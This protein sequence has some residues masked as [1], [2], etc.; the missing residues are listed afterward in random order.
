MN[1]KVT[2]RRSTRWTVGSLLMILLAAGQAMGQDWPQ[3]GHDATK[4]MVSP[5]AKNILTD[6]QPGRRKG[7]SEHIDPATTRNIRWIAKLG[8]Q[9]YGN[10]T[11]SNGRVFIGT[12]NASPRDPK[13]KG[14]RSTVY[15]LDEDTGQLLWQFNLRKLGAG[16]VSDWE[17]LGICSSPTVDGKHVYVVT[18]LGEVVCLDV[19]GMANGNNG[20]V[21]NEGQYLAGPGK[22]AI[23]M[24]ATDADVIWRFDMRSELGVFPH[25]VTSSSALVFGNRV[26]ATTS[27]GVDWSHVNIP[28]PRAPTLIAMD[29][30]TGKLSG[31]ESSGISERLLHCNWSSPGAGEAN[32]RPLVFFGGGDGFCYAF[33]PVPVPDEDG[34]GI[35]KEAWR[36]DCN[37]AKYRTKEG[38]PIRYATHDGPS[39]L[40]ATPVFHK[41]R[42]YIAVG[43]DPEHGEGLGALSCIDAT[44]RGDIS[45]NGLIWRYTEI[46][47]TISTLSIADG[48]V[49][50]AD[51]AGIVHCLDAI[52]GEVFWKHD[53]LGHIW[54]STLVADGKL[55]VGNEDGVL[56]ILKTGKQKQLIAEIEFDGPIY[57]SPVV[58]ND[59]LYIATMTHLFAIGK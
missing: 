11:V 48:L 27:N 58:A 4:N 56:T 43:Q 55:F 54:G 22:P 39:E 42:V 45:Q 31:E 32:G 1:R 17:Y 3:W 53:T 26:Y 44:K 14:D 30:K 21:Q 24:T 23:K 37:P 13:Y 2:R 25:N 41:D 46:N 33:D 51:Y 8:S 57:S 16:K 9:S 49:Y 29:K 28:A 59:T 36:F 38:E 20:P 19:H 5:T 50:A 18:N 7:R 6:F 34:Y 35:L 52:S 40:I 47:R 12:N 10:P 15:C